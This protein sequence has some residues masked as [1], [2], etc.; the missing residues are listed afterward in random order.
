MAA[1]RHFYS[2]GP[3]MMMGSA[4]TSDSKLK[5]DGQVLMKKRIS[6]PSLDFMGGILSFLEDEWCCVL[7]EALGEVGVDEAVILLEDDE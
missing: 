6:S 2:A 1:R 4:S 7:S 3:V 5:L